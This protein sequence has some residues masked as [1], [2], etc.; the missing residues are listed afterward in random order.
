LRI[1]EDDLGYEHLPLLKIPGFFTSK[2]CWWLTNEASVALIA[3]DYIAKTTRMN[4]PFD[5]FEAMA[6]SGDEL[7]HHFPVVDSYL[8]CTVPRPFPKMHSL[9][10]YYYSNQLS[11]PHGL[12]S[13]NPR[14]ARLQFAHERETYIFVLQS[15]WHHWSTGRRLFMIP[16]ITLMGMYNTLLDRV[17]KEVLGLPIAPAIIM[18]KLRLMNEGHPF[19]RCWA[20]TIS[21]DLPLL[22]STYFWWL[23]H[24]DR[25]REDIENQD[26][27]FNGG[28]TFP[29]P[30]CPKELQQG[31]SYNQ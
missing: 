2:T 12:N 16:Q 5:A 24:A 30:L 18:D 23:G 28:E 22:E 9:A 13:Q 4:V 14:R 10:S 11:W 8:G 25:I 21:S 3:Q 26:F 19:D 7:S 31:S 27:T 6:L 15:V 29:M 20:N 1:R 17:P